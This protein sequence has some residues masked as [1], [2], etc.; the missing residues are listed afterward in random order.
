MFNAESN[1]GINFHGYNVAQNSNVTVYE[2]YTNKSKSSQFV[3]LILGSTYGP[4]YQYYIM[5]TVNRTKFDL[6]IGLSGVETHNVDFSRTG[7]GVEIGSVGNVTNTTS[8]GLKYAL[9]YYG[10]K[11]VLDPVRKVTNESYNS[12][13]MG[14][15]L[16]QSF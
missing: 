6:T 12:H 15:T 11:T 2:T 14:L 13:S 5:P 16:I 9:S 4:Y 8:I 3:G 10:G 1:Y 7:F